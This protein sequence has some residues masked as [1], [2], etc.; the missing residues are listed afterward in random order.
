[1]AIIESVNLAY[2]Y[3]SLVLVNFINTARYHHTPAAYVNK[4][5]KGE[6]VL[7]SHRVSFSLSHICAAG[8]AWRK[9]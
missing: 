3:V 4:D 1:M 9:M 2:K 7:I 5:V 6:F 8:V